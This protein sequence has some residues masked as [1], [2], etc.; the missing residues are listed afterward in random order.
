[1]LFLELAVKAEVVPSPKLFFDIVQRQWNN[2]G[3]GLPPSRS[4]KKLYNV[5]SDLAE[6]LQVPMVDKPVATLT[7]VALLPMDAIDCLRPDDKKAELS[8]CKAHQA[9]AWAVKA[10]TSTSFFNRASLLWL[11]QM[12]EQISPEDVRVHQDIN[13]LV[14]AAEFS[15]DATLN[16]SRCDPE[17]QQMRP[18]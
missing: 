7:S 11:R 17:F 3:A 2:S 6:I 14:A 1:M 18:S 12:Q 9:A 4:E 10:V 5:A 8:L 16:F 13:K 15:A